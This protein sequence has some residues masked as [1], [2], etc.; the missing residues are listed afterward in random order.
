[1]SISNR[2]TATAFAA[3]ITLVAACVD[4]SPVDYVPRDSGAADA[5]TVD[6]AGL[7]ASCRQCVTAGTC[8]PSYDACAQDPKCG[9]FLSC[10]LVAYCLNFS[11]ADLANAPACLGACRADAGIGDQADPSIGLFVPVLLCAQS[12]SQ[13]ASECDVQ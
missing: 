6:A 1:M 5:R 4:T 13:C 2:S 8:N 3:G 11:M 7:I 12:A 10:M 9:P